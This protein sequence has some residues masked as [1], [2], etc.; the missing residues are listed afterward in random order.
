M[1]DAIKEDQLRKQIAAE[2]ERLNRE[3]KDRNKIKEGT[4]KP[5][6]KK[7]FLWIKKPESVEQQ[8]TSPIQIL[9]WTNQNGVKH[10]VVKRNILSVAEKSTLKL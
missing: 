8:V 7:G 4:Y 9:M 6:P 10:A 5:S 3:K 2:F 1:I